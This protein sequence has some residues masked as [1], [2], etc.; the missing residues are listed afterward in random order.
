MLSHTPSS[1]SIAFF[2]H[3]LRQ[4]SQTA[5]ELPLSF[6]H[7]ADEITLSPRWRVTT[8]VDDAISPLQRWLHATTFRYFFFSVSEG[9]APMTFA[10]ISD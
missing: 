2:S 1:Y 3:T 5:T 8:A 6:L 4:S 10:V 7:Y 9:D